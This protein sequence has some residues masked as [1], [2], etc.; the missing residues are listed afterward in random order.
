ME[1]R[2]NP[3]FLGLT[4]T[5]ILLGLG[6]LAAVG[7]VGYLVYKQQQSTQT[8]TQ[9]NATSSSDLDQ[10]GTNIGQALS[11]TI[12]YAATDINPPPPQ[13]P[14]PAPPGGWQGTSPIPV[15]PS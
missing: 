3:V 13:I 12:S 8:Q 6:G 10:L 5:D 15:P 7:I 2:E 1:S 9:T 14:V 4:G 11:P